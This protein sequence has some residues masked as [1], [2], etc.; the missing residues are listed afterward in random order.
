ML[1]LK[2]RASCQCFTNNTTSC[3][4]NVTIAQPRNAPPRPNRT[5]AYKDK[6]PDDDT[7]VQTFVPNANSVQNNYYQHKMSNRTLLNEFQLTKASGNAPI[8]TKYGAPFF[9]IQGTSQ[10]SNYPPAT[11]GVST[12]YIFWGYDRSGTGPNVGQLNNR[13]APISNPT[14]N[15]ITLGYQEGG[16]WHQSFYIHFDTPATGGNINNISSIAFYNE[17]GIKVREYTTVGADAGQFGTSTGYYWWWPASNNTDNV[18]TNSPYTKEQEYA[19]WSNNTGKLAI[20]FN[21][22]P[23]QTGFETKKNSVLF[24]RQGKPLTIGSS[25]NNTNNRLLRLKS[26]AMRK[27]IK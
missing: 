10:G 11:S 25:N 7:V 20:S 6:G 4:K 1:R 12:Q 18:V 8:Y 17:S 14:S 3:A 5:K 9:L 13:K 15:I 26:N 22:L 21:G 19:F 24:S 23:T 16:S 27:S 2:S